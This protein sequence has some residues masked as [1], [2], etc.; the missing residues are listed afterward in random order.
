MR[1]FSLIFLMI[2]LVLG[3]FS[4]VR[5]QSQIQVN[6]LDIESTFGEQISIKAE[7]SSEIP[8]KNVQVFI[9]PDKLASS[10]IGETI[11]I[12]PD[13]IHY[14]L[15]LSV[16]P[17][18]V[19]S[20]INFWFQ[21]ELDNGDLITSETF[22]FDYI[23]TRFDWQSL[24]TDEFEIYWYQGNSDF[25]EQVLS[26]AYDGLE[27]IREFV[28]VPQPEKIRFFIY[29]S[30]S[31]MQDTLSVAGAVSDLIAGH[32]NSTLGVIVVSIPPDASQTLEIKR[33]IPH[34]LSHVLL[35]QKLGNGY[36]NLPQWL[37]EGLASAAELFPN[38]NYPILLN[39][40]YERDALIPIAQLCNRFPSDAAN[41]QLAY[42]QAASFTWYLQGMYGYEK[43]EALLA[44][45]ADGLDCE[46]GIAQVYGDTLSY[47]ERGWRQNEF[48]ENPFLALLNEIGPWLILLGVILTPIFILFFGG[49]RKKE[50][51][52]Q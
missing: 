3:V 32:A 13:Q 26:I 44:S 46:Q 43:M 2:I 16:N 30:A 42:A 34:E 45:Y 18:Q 4:L 49:R 50:N 27:R 14:T 22:H 25:G 51:S 52:R 39:R 29:A 40:A 23:D 47:L 41:F 1:R 6:V 35:Y 37:N 21:I 31:E 38:P 15:D 10:V 12:P 19:F 48:Q 5:G 20:Q 36:A 24:N 17:L 33:Q 7:L 11:F 9:Q 8:I 28:Q